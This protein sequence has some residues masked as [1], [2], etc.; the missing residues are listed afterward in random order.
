MKTVKSTP[1]FFSSSCPEVTIA[2]NFI[3][4]IT[5]HGIAIMPVYLIALLSEFL[6]DLHTTL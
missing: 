2:F 3:S 5:V 1:F 4:E 6:L